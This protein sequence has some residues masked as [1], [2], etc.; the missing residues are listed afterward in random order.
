ME[1]KKRVTISLDPALLAAVD[2][3]IDRSAGS[4]RSA[5]IEEALREWSKARRFEQLEREIEAYYRSLSVAER[6]EDRQWIRGV[7]ADSER[8]WR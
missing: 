3:S 6:E 4:S 1:G 8:L 7:A 5:V 2:Q